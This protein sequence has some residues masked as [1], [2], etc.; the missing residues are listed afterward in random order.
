MIK[1][2]TPLLFIL[3]FSASAQAQL[4]TSADFKRQVYDREYTGGII[5]H[6]KGYGLNGR[7][8]KYLDGYNKHGLEI[9]LVK[10]R[11]P[12][13]VRTP[14]QFSNSSRGYVYGRINTFY[15]MRTGYAREKILY[16][17]TDKGSISISLITNFGFSLGLLKPIYVQVFKQSSNGQGFENFLE[18]E[19]YNPENNSTSIVYG[20]ANFF[21]GLGETSLKPGIYGK[22]AT[23]FDFDLLDKKVTSIETGVVYDYYFREIE[24]FYEQEGGEDINLAGFFQLYF[25]INFGYKKN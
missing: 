25:A 20:E 24:I 23:S 5:F 7:Y 12:K 10:L 14:N 15:A 17:K 4:E 22:V 9:D 8:F 6:S 3:F 2:F 21:K 19:R 13:E 1:R 11:H 18:T 16:D